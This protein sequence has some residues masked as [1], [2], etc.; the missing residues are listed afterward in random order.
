[1]SRYCIVNVDDFGISH[2]VNRAVVEAHRA[3][4]VTS[5]SLM[6]NGAAVDEAV[7]L[8]KSH[9]ELSVGI[10]VNFTNEGGPPIVD[11]DNAVAGRA[12]LERQMEQF[13]SL[14]G[15]RPSHLD[16]HHHVHRRASLAP[17]FASAAEDAGIPLREQSA[18]HWVGSFYGAWDG[19]THPEQ[20]SIESLIRIL[21]G[22]EPGVT[23]VSTH[24]GYVD[25]SLQ[26]EYHAE[27]ELELATLLDP[28]LPEIIE[29]LGIGL[30]N[31]ANVELIG[32]DPDGVDPDRAGRS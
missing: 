15:R 1:V 21:G 12:E 17:V 5:A 2:G 29:S 13:E 9:S 6:V 7:A 20:I 8:A 10:H 30:V 23:E 3:G 16:S 18:V 11:L 14:M 22:L 27:R 4:V 19:E 28:R 26:T 24:V 25:P 31:Y 32:S